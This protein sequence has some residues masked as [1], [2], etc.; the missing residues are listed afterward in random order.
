MIFKFIVYL[1]GMKTKNKKL[2]KN[3][4]RVKKHAKEIRQELKNSGMKVSAKAI[5][6]L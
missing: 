5:S 4:H 6:N 3:S 1:C 2:S